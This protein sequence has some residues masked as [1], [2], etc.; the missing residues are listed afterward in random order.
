MKIEFT[1]EEMENLLYA[2]KFFRSLKEKKVFK[3]QDKLSFTLVQE[4]LYYDPLEGHFYWTSAAGRDKEGIRAEARNEDNYRSIT[5]DGK[6]YAA[7]RIAWFYMEGYFPEH[8]IDHIN[9][10]KYDNRWENLRHVTRACNARNTGLMKTNT[11]GVKGIT[12][13][14][15]RWAVTIGHQGIVLNLK[16]YVDFYTAVKVRWEAEKILK[17]PDC[18]TTSTA[19]LWLKQYHKQ[20]EQIRALIKSFKENPNDNHNPTI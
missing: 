19:Y 6:S 9:M 5:I 18:Q 17:Y 11:S 2:E 12:R 1:E 3:R 16:S 7:H 8:E 15:K 10:R 4:L 20:Q 14:K 13:S